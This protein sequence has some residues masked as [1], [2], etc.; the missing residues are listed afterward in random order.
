MLPILFI[1]LCKPREAPRIDA[2][3]FYLII[4]CDDHEAS[5]AY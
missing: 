1:P 4:E 5:S 2:F 3:L